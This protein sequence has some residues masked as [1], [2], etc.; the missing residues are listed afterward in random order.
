MKFRGNSLSTIVVSNRG[1]KFH[2]LISC[3]H[4]FSNL[5]NEDEADGYEIQFSVKDYCF[6]RSDRLLGTTVLQLSQVVQMASCACSCPLGR[7]LTMDNIGHTILRILAQRTTDEVAQEFFH[8]KVALRD[9][10]AD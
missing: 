2:H 1:N 8:L 6:A 9:A 10:T 3:S 4:F 5:G 7:S